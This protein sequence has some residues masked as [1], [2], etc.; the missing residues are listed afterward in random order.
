[1][2]DYFMGILSHYL[3]AFR[4]MYGC[5]H[6][7]LK[8]VEDWKYALDRGEH[9]GAIL[10][11]LSK[12]F[13]YLPHRLLLSKLHAYGVSLDACS[14]IRNYLQGRRQ[15][16]KINCTRSEWLPLSKGVP[17]GSV[18][19][20]LLFNLFI[21]DIF[22]FLESKCMLYSYADDN[23]ISYSHT[24]MNNLQLRLEQCAAIAVDWFT[25]NEMEANP[26]KFHGIVIPHGLTNVPTSFIV[27]SMEVP[28]ET[29]AKV[30][31]IFIDND[32]NF[33]R[34]S[35]EICST[36]SIFISISHHH[37]CRLIAYN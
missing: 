1:M 22:Y 37:T 16:V 4:K 30:L 12:A 2:Y 18:L 10:M 11:D 25:I 13:D 7:L 6:V 15:R 32:L 33:A 34:Q 26:S 31:G 27:S 8:L 23:S 21:Y 35:K 20:P 36:H 28:I 14:L 17:Q 3:S 24:D 29:N 9:V 19:G 5:N